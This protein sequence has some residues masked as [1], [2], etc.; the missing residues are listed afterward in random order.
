MKC[1]VCGN[2]TFND[3]DYAGSICKECFW[4]YDTV[5]VED[6]D[7]PGGAN[8]HSLNEYK[9]IYKRLLADNPNFS[10]RNEEDRKLIVNLDH[11]RISDN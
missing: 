11:N 9:K 6:P 5:Q 10:C 2:N 3:Y 8:C 7:Y 1:P 4:E